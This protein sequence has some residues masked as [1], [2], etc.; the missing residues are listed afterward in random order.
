M[1]LRLRNIINIILYNL[2]ITIFRRRRCQLVVMKKL[3]G[4]W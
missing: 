1:K 4:S 2:Y 3:D